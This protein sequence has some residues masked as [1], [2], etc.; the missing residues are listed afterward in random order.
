[1]SPVASSDLKLKLSI[2]TGAAG[3]ASA[4]TT[5]GSLGKYISTTELVTATSHNLFDIISGAENVASESEYRCIF[6]HNAHASITAE[7]CKVYLSAEVAGGANTAIGIDPTA[8]SAIGS[9]GAQAVEIADENTAP[10]GVVFTA[11]TTSGTAL[12]IGNLTP[13]QCRA[14]W[15]RRT[16]TN[17]AAA[18]NDGATLTVVCESL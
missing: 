13:G 7:N 4:G 16:A 2:K 3:N 18:T 14:I 15:I 11:P 10:A 12:S 1:M 9:A 8:A 6:L 17:S 5:A